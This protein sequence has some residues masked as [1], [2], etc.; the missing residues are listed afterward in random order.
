MAIN[1]PSFFAQNGR[2]DSEMIVIDK[3]SMLYQVLVFIDNPINSLFV[4]I[5]G[6]LVSGYIYKVQLHRKISHS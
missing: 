4:L 2:R 1:L 5:V 3:E 6:G